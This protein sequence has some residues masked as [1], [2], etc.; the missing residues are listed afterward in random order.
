[1]NEGFQYGIP[2]YNINPSVAGGQYNNGN[3]VTMNNVA[4]ALPTATVPNVIWDVL[5]PF[6]VGQK[7]YGHDAFIKFYRWRK[8]ILPWVEWSYW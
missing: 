3:Y 2:S 8:N 6:Q 1:M 5:S 4:A 7:F